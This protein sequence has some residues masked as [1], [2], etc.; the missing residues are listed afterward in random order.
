MQCEKGPR[1]SRE[2][3]VH[4]SQPRGREKAYL[5]KSS[6]SAGSASCRSLSIDSS[7]RPMSPGVK[8]RLHSSDRELI[9]MGSLGRKE[10][11]KRAKADKR[12]KYQQLDSGFFVVLIHN[13]QVIQNYF[14]FYA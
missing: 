14:M 11:E 2:Q 6:V 9:S 3:A 1:E 13:P 7:P 10:E 8:T 12:D 5:T 4:S